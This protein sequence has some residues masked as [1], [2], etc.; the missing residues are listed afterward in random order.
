MHPFFSTQVQPW[1]TFNP[2]HI[3]MAQRPFPW[4]DPSAYQPTHNPLM[5]NPGVYRGAFPGFEANPY[6]ANNY[7]GI[8]PRPVF[9]VPPVSSEFAH[10]VSPVNFPGFGV[11][12]YL[13]PENFVAG[14]GKTA[15]NY[16]PPEFLEFLRA[17]LQ[18]CGKALRAVA[19]A[20]EH[21]NGD[22]K[23]QAHLSATAQ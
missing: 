15:G 21:E 13:S 10:G 9:H 12:E 5:Y 17:E 18:R 3:A 7:A 19:P 2:T 16:L 20:L 11:S 1:Q 22:V 23:E 8:V 14:F 4:F 6:Y